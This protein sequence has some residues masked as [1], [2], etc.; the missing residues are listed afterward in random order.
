MVAPPRVGVPPAVGVRWPSLT[1]V[2]GV[3]CPARRDRWQYT[4]SFDYVEVAAS[5]PGVVVEATCA[6]AHY[7][8]PGYSPPF[9]TF[10]DKATGAWGFAYQHGGYNVPPDTGCRRCLLP[11]LNTGVVLAPYPTLQVRTCRNPGTFCNLGWVDGSSEQATQ[12]RAGFFYESGDRVR[13]C[14]RDSGQWSGDAMVR[15]HTAQATHLRVRG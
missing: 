2:G 3:A 10:C 1:T 8:A 7:V 9:R 11:A 15:C 6:A 5:A 4:S 12:C 14:L 13:E